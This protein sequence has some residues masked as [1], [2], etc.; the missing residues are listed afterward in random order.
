MVIIP[1]SSM[2]GHRYNPRSGQ[3]KD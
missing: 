2:V 3:I 1:D